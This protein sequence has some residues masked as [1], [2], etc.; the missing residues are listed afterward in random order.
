MR[1]SERASVRFRSRLSRA[2]DEVFNGNFSAT[3]VCNTLPPGGP[4]LPVQCLVQCRLL[5]GGKI[6]IEPLYINICRYAAAGRSSLGCGP[7][8]LGG[9]ARRG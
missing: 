8:W 5:G 3:L 4:T 9:S 1:P 6:S 2:D 7:S